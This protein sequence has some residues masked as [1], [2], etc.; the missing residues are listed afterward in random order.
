[1]HPTQDNMIHAG[2][3]SRSA[4]RVAALRAAH[5]LLD[6]P[7]V[8]E[9]PLALAILGAEKEAKIRTDPERFNNP[10]LRGL[11]AALVV[12][13]KVAED[14]LAKAVHDGVRQYVVL[15]AGLD[16]FG[17]RNPWSGDGLRVFEVD[18]PS[19]QRWKCEM[20]ESA[21]IA[22]PDSLTFVG[23]DFE[24]DV[25]AQ[26][27]KEAGFRPDQPAFFS[28][29][30]V[31]FY[32]TPDAVFETLKFVASL[33]SG[34]AIVF[35]YRVEPS[36]LDERA[37]AVNEYLALHVAGQGEPWKSAFDPVALCDTL[38]GMGFTEARDLT[39]DA[40]NARYLAQREDKLAVG[41][42]FRLMCAKV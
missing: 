27:L 15:G 9:D 5:Q 26:R 35:D 2:E 29:L 42:A 20:L 10:F 37:R 16:T 38:R 19:T 23:V 32:L 8:F 28:W 18:H 3:P 40:L 25:L 30:G 11:R 34:S 7:V 13:S 14:E 31:V 41:G 12:R 6:E 36:L 33:P 39:P 4:L 17:C 21:A 22:Q 1:M 24:R